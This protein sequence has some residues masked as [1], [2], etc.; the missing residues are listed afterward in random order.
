MIFYETVRFPFH[1]FALRIGQEG[2]IEPVKD[3]PRLFSQ[4][5]SL[6]LLTVII[7]NNFGK[8]G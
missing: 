8:V 2:G 1:A 5:H 6:V 3:P 4:I 7:W